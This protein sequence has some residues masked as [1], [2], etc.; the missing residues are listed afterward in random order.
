MKSR[1]LNLIG[2][3]LCILITELAGIIGS[4]FT[5]T[6]LSP[7]YENINKPWLTPPDWVFGPVWT[8]LYLLMGISLYLVLKKGIDKTGV[9]VAVSI[10]T[11]QLVLNIL[12]SFVFFGLES[13]KGGFIVILLLW[14]A[15]IITI[16]K[17]YSVSKTA[18]YLLVPYILW[19]SYATVLNFYIMILN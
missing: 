7:W 14:L 6:G 15:I 1:F 19:V 16:F 18:A 17:F 3:A 5:R 11:F 9:K 13:I 2:L 4:I 10:F 8:T 12:W